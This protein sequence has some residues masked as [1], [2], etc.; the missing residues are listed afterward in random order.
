M[1]FYLFCSQISSKE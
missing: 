1:D